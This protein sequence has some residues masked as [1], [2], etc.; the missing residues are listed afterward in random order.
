MAVHAVLLEVEQDDVVTCPV[1][2]EIPEY[3]IRDT[4]LFM[5]KVLYWHIIPSCTELGFPCPDKPVPE[6]MEAYA[7]GLHI[8]DQLIF[9]GTAAQ[10]AQGRALP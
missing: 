5:R 10:V 4:D 2:V 1:H 3:F 7:R 9:A 8:Q 6:S